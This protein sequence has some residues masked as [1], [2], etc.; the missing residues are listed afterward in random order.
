[1][2]FFRTH[3]CALLLILAVGWNLSSCQEFNADG[4]I[5]NLKSVPRGKMEIGLGQQTMEL[6]PC[7]VRH[8]KSENVIQIVGW[9]N[10][11][12]R[13]YLELPGR[14]RPE[15][16]FEAIEPTLTMV[17]PSKPLSEGEEPVYRSSDLAIVF[18]VFNA[19]G[20][21]GRLSG[22]VEDLML[23]RTHEIRGVFDCRLE[24]P[25]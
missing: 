7:A 19:H 10:D 25:P 1:M 2:F 6:Q 3:I 24:Q 20:A 15:A 5:L 12:M 4:T 16:P 18:E 22:R 9:D 17:H 23:G 8:S 14:T 21:K 11:I 13:V